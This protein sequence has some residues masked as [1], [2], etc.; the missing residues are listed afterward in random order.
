MLRSLVGSEMCIR[1]R[2][3]IQSTMIQP[4]S[5]YSNEAASPRAALCRITVGNRSMVMCSGMSQFL[6]PKCPCPLYLGPPSNTWFLGPTRIHTPNGTSIGSA[7]FAGLL[8]V[9]TDTD[10]QTNR[11]RYIG[12]HRPHLCVAVLSVRCSQ[13]GLMES[14]VVFLR[15]RHH[16]II[17]LFSVSTIAVFWR[18][19]IHRSF[20]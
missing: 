7:V 18:I 4:T 1:D 11:P 16:C 13:I 10:R 2:H 12:N 15:V 8:S 20:I 19:L 3:R 14:C 17:V 9:T 6:S 5:C